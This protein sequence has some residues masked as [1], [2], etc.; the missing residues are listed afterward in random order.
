ML[1]IDCLAANRKARN[2]VHVSSLASQVCERTSSYIVHSSYE[3]TALAFSDSCNTIGAATRSA[4]PTERRLRNSMAWNI[5]TANRAAFHHRLAYSLFAGFKGTINVQA[6]PSVPR[7]RFQQQ[8]PVSAL[9]A[10]VS[11]A[12]L[13]HVYLV[14]SLPD[15]NHESRSGAVTVAADGLA[16]CR[17]H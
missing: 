9:R 1:R 4:D 10:H 7:P 6:L 15:T 17:R 5:C 13:I 12:L 16:L 8:G 2:R 3:A 14:Q 11:P